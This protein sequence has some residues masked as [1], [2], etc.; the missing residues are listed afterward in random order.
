MTI[1]T[2]CLAGNDTVKSLEGQLCDDTIRDLNKTDPDPDNKTIISADHTNTQGDNFSLTGNVVINDQGKTFRADQITY[3][4]STGAVKLTGNVSLSNKAMTM[5]AKKGTGNIKKFTAKLLDIH[6]QFNQF[7]GQGVADSVAIHDRQRS[8]F[9]KITYSTCKKQQQDWLIKAR[10]VTIDQNKQLGKAKDVSFWFMDTPVFYLPRF[11]FPT[12]D[13][14]KSGFL[15]PDFGQTTKNGSELNIPWYWNIAPNRDALLN[16][17]YMSDRGLKIESEYRYLYKN[18]KG[19][20]KLEHLND[21]LIKENRYLASFQHK[22][23]LAKNWSI[24]A[25]INHVSDQQYFDDL[26]SG[27]NVSNITHL[28]RSIELQRDTSLGFLL[29]RAHEYQSLNVANAYQRLP[30]FIIDLEKPGHNNKLLYSLKGEATRFEHRDIMTTGTRLDIKPGIQYEWGSSSYYIKPGAKLRYTQYNLNNPGIGRADKL[31]RTT[32]IFSLDSGIFLERPVNFIGQAQTLTLEPRL[33]YLYAAYDDQG[34]FPVF[35]TTVP[36]FRFSELFRE[37]HFAGPDRQSNA[38]QLTLALDSRLI[39]SLDGREK[40]RLSAGQIFYFDDRRV[41]LP[42]S[43]VETSSSSDFVGEMEGT[44]ARYTHLRI[45]GL[46]DVDNNQADKAIATLR[47]N[48]DRKHMV[49]MSY[50]YQRGIIEQSNFSTRWRL[51]LN[52]N[53]IARWTYSL[54]DKQTIDS[55]AGLEYGTCCWSVQFAGRRFL[56]SRG[57]GMDNAFYIQLNL[58]GFGNVGNKIDTLLDNTNLG[59]RTRSTVQ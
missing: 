29:L 47:Y 42:G 53:G 5:S 25:D 2:Q 28:P 10:E 56:S 30:Q 7:A 17:H 27:L 38:N 3:N 55:V 51:G 57:I 54:R 8:T 18:S 26:G 43:S 52:W 58:K 33:F 44:I 46:W 1:S 23:M 12:G 35:D 48:R 59:Y 49:N 24:K 40:L 41:F 39:D 20:L 34:N 22:G 4:R 32:P 50:R 6:Y 14:R 19:T 13:M 45:S 11:S 31:S 21:K 36:D 16:L 9:S 15:S 37:N